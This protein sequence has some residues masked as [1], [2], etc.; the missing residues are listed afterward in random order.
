MKENKKAE[1]QKMSSEIVSG[2]TEWRQQNPEATFCE[3]ERETM[4]RMGQ[5]QARM[6][7]EIAMESAVKD[8]EA[9]N[10]PKCA[11]CGEKM[12]KSSTEER[13][14]QAQGGHEIVLERTYAICPKCG[15]GIFPPG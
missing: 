4:K 11:E 2:L 6:M 1:L 3:I 15:A 12:K 13:R 7:Q 5:L 8:W 14:L 9:E 10:G